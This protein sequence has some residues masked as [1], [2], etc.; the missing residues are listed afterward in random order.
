MARSAYKTRRFMTPDDRAEAVRLHRYD[1]LVDGVTRRYTPDFWVW[2]GDRLRSLIDVK[3]L[4]SDEQRR[5][6]DLFQE[7][8][9]HLPFEM[10]T[11]SDLRAMGCMIQ[12]RPATVV[13]G[14]K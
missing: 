1:V 11:A 12:A 14:W 2:N 9:P 8:Y 7:Q 3:G 5:K 13:T 4:Y 6:I 10:W